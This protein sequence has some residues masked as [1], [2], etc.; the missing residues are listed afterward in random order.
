MRR[1]SALVCL[2]A[3]AS[4]PLISQ[5]P[6]KK[7]DPSQIGNRDVDCGRLDFKQCHDSLN[8]VET[9]LPHRHFSSRRRSQTRPGSLCRLLL[10]VW[11]SKAQPPEEACLPASRIFWKLEAASCLQLRIVAGL[12]R[13]PREGR[14]ALALTCRICA[15]SKI[16]V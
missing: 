13:T 7:D 4:A 5:N 2:L 16:A 15:K 12:S 3:L 8:T 1:L 10:C 14:D 11:S 9:Q 6:K